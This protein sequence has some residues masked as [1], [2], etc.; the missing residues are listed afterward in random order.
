MNFV[1][2]A[3]NGKKGRPSFT[4]DVLKIAATYIGT[5]VGAGFASGQSILQFFTVNG[6]LG[7]F[8]IVVSTALF[9]WIGTKMMVLSHRI[10]AFSYQEF[11][12]YLFGPHVG[13]AANALT[14][15]ILFG[16]TT[17]ML[18]GTGS[19]FEERLG[20][21]YQLGI[22][23]SLVLG[24]L[25]MMGDMKGIVAANSLVVPL[26]IVFLALVAVFAVGAD[27]LFPAVAWRLAEWHDLL[28]MLNPFTYVA[29]NMA[30]VQSVLVPLGGE[31]EN[32]K[33]LKWGG[34]WGGIGLGLMLVVSHLAMQERMPGIVQYDIPMAEIIEDLGWL[35]H[36]LFLLVVY[37]EIFTTLIGNVFG[38]SRQLQS[39]WKLPGNAVVAAVLAAGYLI[40]QVGFSPL[41]SY[42]YPF[43]GY[44]GIILLIWLAVKKMPTR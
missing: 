8:G 28:W 10:K 23:T 38:I 33:V 30:F 5:V 15:V 42:L 6:Y 19:I 11:N 1:S 24:Y 22:V 20:L 14:F 18:S 17:V 3:R 12:S 7:L 43:F 31:A 40:S 36:L 37:G 13:K 25:V 2:A 35:V 9:S 26:M 32:E 39:L 44:I 4:A 27:G 16:V 41:L 29:L 21:P 34:F